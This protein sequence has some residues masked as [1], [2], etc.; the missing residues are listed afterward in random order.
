MKSRLYTRIFDL[1]DH[2][3]RQHGL[4][5]TCLSILLWLAAHPAGVTQNWLSR[6]TY[7]SKQVVNATIKKFQ[8][9]GWLYVETVTTDKRHKQLYLTDLGR[10]FAEKVGAPL[11]K[12]E[13]SALLGLASHG[14][15]EQD[16]L[17]QRYCQELAQLVA[18]R[19]DR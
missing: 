2:Y 9:K 6:E 7:S 19:I 17:G 11:E 1:Y 16:E 12:A 3:A 8:Q 15:A 14:Q 4:T 13:Q 18:E 5:G 10:Q